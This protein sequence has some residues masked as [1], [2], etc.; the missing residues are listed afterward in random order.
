VRIPAVIAACD[1]YAQVDTRGEVLE[2]AGNCRIIMLRDVR[3]IVYG[4]S[5]GDSGV[6]III[7]RPFTGRYFN[8]SSRDI[9]VTS[10][11]DIVRI[12]TSGQVA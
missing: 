6:K 9:H 1:G 8:K 2:H 3:R 4:C 12:G 11:C 7:G 10:N 5:T